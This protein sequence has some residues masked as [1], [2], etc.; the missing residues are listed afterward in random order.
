MRQDEADVEEQ[1]VKQSARQDGYAEPSI[2]RATGS[3]G[4]LLA[5]QSDQPDLKDKIIIRTPV[6][7]DREPGRA[8]LRVLHAQSHFAA[9][10]FS[11]SKFDKGADRLLKNPTNMVGLLA[12]LNGRLVGAAWA[13]A[14]EY[15]GG[16][17][18][19]IATAHFI[20]VDKAWCG[21]LLSAKVFLR[22]V[23]GLRRWA[24]SRNAKHLTI[25]VTTGEHFVATDRLLR[26]AGL[27]FV[28][29]SYVGVE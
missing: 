28:G 15:F 25:H 1:M 7:E 19:V 18:V 8:L 12:E 5:G 11:D 29:G 9:I 6:P 16:D 23:Q 27:K 20:G 24:D 10:P 2:S 26:A 3:V 13:G 4:N 21:D 22:L 14:G 17:G